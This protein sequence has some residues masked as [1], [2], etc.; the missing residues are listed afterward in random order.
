MV[1]AKAKLYI[2]SPFLVCSGCQTIPTAAALYLHDSVSAILFQPVNGHL[3]IYPC[4][5]GKN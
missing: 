1:K 2:Q 4:T 3:G 5:A